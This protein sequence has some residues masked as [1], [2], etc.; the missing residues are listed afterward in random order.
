M[1]LMKSYTL[2]WELDFS[3]NK[4]PLQKEI[5]FNEGFINLANELWKIILRKR[6]LG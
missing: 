4:I 3:I 6:L 2:E 5:T 1:S